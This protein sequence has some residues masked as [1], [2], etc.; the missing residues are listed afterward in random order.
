MPSCKVLFFSISHLLSNKLSLKKAP[1]SRPRWLTPGLTVMWQQLGVGLFN[2][3]VGGGRIW[4]DMKKIFDHPQIKDEQ[5]LTPSYGKFEKKCF[6][7]PKFFRLYTNS[8]WPFFTLSVLSTFFAI[9][10]RQNFPFPSPRMYHFA[11]FPIRDHSFNPLTP[12]L[13]GKCWGL[14]SLG[15]DW[16]TTKIVFQVSSKR[17][18]K[19]FWKY[20]EKE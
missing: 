20:I 12:W 10:P 2:L 11:T 13:R 1:M 4:N 17:F 16:S 14:T 18:E 6:P 7:L 19:D 3:V 5:I 15:E 9:S 8:V